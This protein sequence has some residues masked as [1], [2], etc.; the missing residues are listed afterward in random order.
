M[1]VN[2]EN[3]MILAATI[4]SP[5]LEN[6]KEGVDLGIIGERSSV[7]SLSYGHADV[8]SMRA[9]TIM[10]NVKQCWLNL[11]LVRYIGL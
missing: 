8:K 2:T 11:Q 1:A 7:R 4:A 10:G 5:V 6:L 9:E 3:R